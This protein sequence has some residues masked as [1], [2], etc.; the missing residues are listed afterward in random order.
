VRK[1]ASIGCLYT[2]ELGAAVAT[3]LVAAGSDVVTTCEGRSSDTCG[4]AAAIGLPVLPS[5]AAVV[6]RSDLIVSF[7]P[8]EAALEV[9]RHVAVAAGDRSDFVF[10]D[11][12][13]IGP[14]TVGAIAT[15][16]DRAG[17]AFVDAAIHGLASRLAADGTMYV[18]G[19]G[20]EDIARHFAPAVNVRHVGSAPGTASMLK[21][22]LGGVSKGVVALFLEMA[23]VAR[24]SELLDEFLPACEQYYP[25][26][27]T[28][29][30]RLLPTVPRHAR[31]RSQ[32]MSELEDAVRGLGM[33]PGFPTAAKNLLAAIDVASVAPEDTEIAT[34]IEAIA[35]A[36]PM[37]RTAG[38]TIEGTNQT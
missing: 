22:L 9:A 23:L 24:E 25:G 21:M 4:R 1:P 17:I 19:I 16:L 20:A 7:V 30:D 32:E 5:V 6:E 29:I 37:H 27:M 3:R 36:G 38:E 12:N 33:R 31:R 14:D 8:V 34:I 35:A 2:G 13:S 18:S 10:V 26:V 28:A 15:T 11:A